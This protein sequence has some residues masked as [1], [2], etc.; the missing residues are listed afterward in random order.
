MTS[1]CPFTCGN[2]QPMRVFA[3][4][5]CALLPAT[6]SAADRIE[7]LYDIA[8]RGFRVGEL[9]LT[10][11]EASGRYSVAAA[12]DSTGAVGF[13]RPFSYRARSWGAVRDGLPA[14]DRYTE[15]AD[16]GRRQSEAELA[17]DAGVPTVVRYGSPRP[18]GAD[19]PDPRTQGGTL[20]PLS[21]IWAVLRGPSA[22][23]RT[24]VVF[25]GAR[26]SH[27]RLGA[28]SPVDG[29][30][31]CTGEYRRLK[32]FTADELSR[33]VA[34]PMTVIYA[35]DAEGVMRAR[36]VEVQSV[37]GLATVDRR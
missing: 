7:A 14:P 24:L 8:I 3:L 22:C 10:S 16:T 26:R 31:A 11:E 17:Y 2:V 30:V 36:R 23:G 15:T 13:F 12:V 28:A 19:S 29:G 27:V 25:D 9:R 1:V 35:P 32:G 4:V 33:H 18:P 6:A 20:D 34:F 21:G 5:L 37:Y